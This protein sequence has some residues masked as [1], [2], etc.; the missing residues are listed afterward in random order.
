MSTDPEMCMFA[1]TKVYVSQ[2][3]GFVDPDHPEKVYHL[4]KALFGLKQV[5]RALYDELSTFLMSIG[6]QIHQ[7]P[8]GVFINQAKYGLEI[9]KKHRMDKCDS[10]GTP[11]ATKPKLD[12]DLSGTPVDQTRYHS[13]I[14]LL[15]YLASNRP[16]LVQVVCYC[17]RYQAWPAENTS[18]STSYEIQFLGEKLFS[19]MSKKQDCS[20]MSTTEAE[21]VALS[22]AITI[23]CNLKHCRTKHINV[24]YHFIKEQVE[25]GIIE[26]YFVITEYQMADMFTKVLSQDRF[27]YL[28]K[29]LRKRCLTPAEL[30]VMANESA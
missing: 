1:L 10:L 19:W 9:L 7:S 6:L 28:V 16:Y 25:Q 21:Y 26:L 11:M 4:K 5:P 30:E 15:M 20:A 27:E 8:R 29:Q 24:C 2:P 12:A 14:G 17:A 3:D 22:S 23:S 18:K 13:M